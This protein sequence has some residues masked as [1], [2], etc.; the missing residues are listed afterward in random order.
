MML[1]IAQRGTLRAVRGQDEAQRVGQ[2]SAAMA[3]EVRLPVRGVD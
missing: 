2:R 1:P 3:K